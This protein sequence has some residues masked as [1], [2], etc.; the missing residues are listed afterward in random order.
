MLSLFNC[1]F[2][3]KRSTKIYQL[4]CHTKKKLDVENQ[5]NTVSKKV[6][7]T[8]LQTLSLYHR[9]K[10]HCK[11]PRLA[12][13][14]KHLLKS[15]HLSTLRGG[16][17]LISLNSLLRLS[18]IQIWEVGT[19]KPRDTYSRDSLTEHIIS[20]H[21]TSEWITSERTRNV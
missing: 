16:T 9:H 19:T 12:I 17:V 21:K 14:P 6:R 11:I 8:N 1:T 4:L 18:W 10:W 20:L 5:Q 3:W 2:C 15:Q 7:N 13:R